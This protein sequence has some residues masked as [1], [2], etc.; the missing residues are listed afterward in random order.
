MVLHSYGYEH[1]VTLHRL[2]MAGLCVASGKSKGKG[3]FQKL[4]RKFGLLSD[5]TVAGSLVGQGEVVSGAA[6]RDDRSSS[7]SKHGDGAVSSAPVI[8]LG[9]ETEDVDD[10][11]F[12]GYSP[13]LAHVVH[14]MSAAA[15]R[16]GES[17]PRDFIAASL[18]A[19]GV[20][21]PAFQEILGAVGFAG[22]AR[23]PLEFSTTGTTHKPLARLRSPSSQTAPVPSQAPTPEDVQSVASAPVRLPDRK[24]VV[25][26]GGATMSEL[27]AM[28]ALA[29]RSG[30][31][32]VFC[33]TSVLSSDRF[34]KEVMDN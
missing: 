9:G 20:N 8:S 22:P 30:V 34:L 14:Q 18:S 2:E 16:T 1:M 13:L 15:S 21:V 32:C 19:E 10:H 24:L 5:G 31:S 28:R 12:Y 25:V 11:V 29:R 27:A 26:L 23:P 33:V 4:A 3:T 6:D 7:G 17:P